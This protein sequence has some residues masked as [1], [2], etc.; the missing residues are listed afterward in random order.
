MI[1]LQGEITAN[2]RIISQVSPPT[3][4]N[5]PQ[6]RNLAV[7]INN[8]LHVLSLDSSSDD[9]G[10]STILLSLEFG[11]NRIDALGWSP[12]ARFVVLALSGL[13]GGQRNVQLVHLDTK[14]PLP[15]MPCDPQIQS[16]FV[17]VASN[18]SDGKSTLSFHTADGKVRQIQLS[19]N[20]P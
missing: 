11:L 1:I 16:P 5:G 8:C 3:S 13:K 6:Q 2:P 15:A 12:C 9:E 4:E 14:R 17:A 20:V 7:A 10:E 18:E 19:I